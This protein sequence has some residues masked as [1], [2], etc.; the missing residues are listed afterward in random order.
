MKMKV[1]ILMVGLLLIG[2]NLYAANGD[3]IVN[4]NLGVGTTTPQAKLHVAGS[5]KADTGTLVY[6]CPVMPVLPSANLAPCTTLCVGQLTTAS[7][8]QYSTPNSD[9]T[10]CSGL[11]SAACQPVG[12]LIIQ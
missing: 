5:I 12:R 9:W 11:T 3:L 2:G 10:S 1:L 6:L 7:S 8:C 4:G